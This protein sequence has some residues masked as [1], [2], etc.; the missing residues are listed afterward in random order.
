[1]ARACETLEVDR[2]RSAACPLGL[3]LNDAAALQMEALGW[4]E[5]LGGL[6][7]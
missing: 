5:D 1:V 6:D 4:T 3:T 2:L 7:A